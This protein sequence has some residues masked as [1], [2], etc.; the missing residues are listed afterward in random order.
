MVDITPTPRVLRT[1]GQIPFATWQC[2]AELIDNSIDG[3]QRAEREGIELGQRRIVISWPTGD[4]SGGQIEVLDTGPGMTL[5]QLANCVRAGYSE[6]DPINNLGLFG[7]GFNIATARLGDRTLILSATADSDVW[8]G[9]EID[10]SELINKK[11][12]DAPT[13]TEPKKKKLEHGTKVIISKLD[14]ANFADIKANGAKL[15][16]QLEEIYTP[17][18]EQL[19]IEIL[20]QGKIL[21][22]KPHCVWS[23]TR[24]VTHKKQSVPAVIDIDEV[25]GESL[26][27]TLRNRYLSADEE[28]DALKHEASGQGL[29]TGVTRRLKRVVGWLGI[30]RYADPNDFGI[31]FVRNGRKILIRDKSVFEFYNQI[32]LKTETEYPIELGGTTGG[33]IVGQLHVD[34]VPPTY[35]KNDFH[36]S[37]YSWREVIDVVRGVGPILPGRRKA[38]GY[39]G[40]N[41]SPLGKLIN[42]YRRVDS[43][44]KCLAAP[45]A[46]AREYA[47]KFDNGDPAFLS[48]EK[49][50]RAAVEQ[51][52]LRADKGASEAGPVD[53]GE[54]ASDSI[55]DY[56]PSG[57]I[58]DAAF[59]STVRIIPQKPDIDPM[60]DLRSRSTKIESLS[61]NYTYPGCT[62]PLLV[63]VYQL[64]TGIIGVGDQGVPAT[65]FRSGNQSEFFYNPRHRLLSTYPTVPTDLLL[66]Y[67]AERIKVRDGTPGRDIGE[68]FS[69]LVRSNFQ[70]HQLD[71]GS[72]QERSRSV[73]E[74][75]REFVIANM[76]LRE[77]EIIDCVHESSGEVEETAIALTLNPIL[78]KK[79]QDKSHGAIDA[80]QF[81]PFKTLVRIIDRFPEEFFDARF[82]CG[83]YQ[84]V[85][86]PEPQATE[87]LKLQI[88]ERIVILLKDLLSVLSD[89]V[90]AFQGQ[91]RKE[92]L[93]RISHSIATLQREIIE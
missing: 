66:V 52:R 61:R 51:D 57:S 45:N 49:W 64:D 91:R 3:F 73:F 54:Y 22:P 17:L 10:F 28:D 58:D 41:E 77:Q 29:P 62:S 37:D 5:E 4:H 8:E 90:L 42:A 7:M 85:C 65:M 9:V 93:Q 11:G 63:S 86:L 23:E 38:M 35:Q 69:E 68:L 74:R 71:L 67:L 25:L 24:Y 75:I 82:F 31:D 88:K 80:V 36:R 83:L 76:S 46:L 15:R 13:K 19:N 70:E 39:E 21:T 33:R 20:V 1:L 18:L 87:R 55:E 56:L 16:R 12:F 26:F 47:T 53:G 6:N 79:F 43:G 27:D 14:P 89:S 92:D 30:Q 72:L 44:T 40:E 48:D 78:L 34:H 59:I 50:W 60:E 32:T 2:L 84:G 81:V